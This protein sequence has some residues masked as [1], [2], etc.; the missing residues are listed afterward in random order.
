MLEIKI[1]YQPFSRTYFHVSTR[2]IS[3]KKLTKQ[4][5]QNPTQNLPQLP[6]PQL[7][8][9]RNSRILSQH[10]H[11]HSQIH[12][13]VSFICLN[14][15]LFYYFCLFVFKTVVCYTRW[16]CSKEGEWSR[17]PDLENFLTL[18]PTGGFDVILMPAS[19]HKHTCNLHY[20]NAM[21][22]IIHILTR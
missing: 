17:N 7:H 16:M 10:S 18:I 3:F 2:K 13:T 11:C 6:L 19:Q 9:P 12:I 15:K 4:Q 20:T 8:T 5:Q 22:F 21:V 14:L 1:L